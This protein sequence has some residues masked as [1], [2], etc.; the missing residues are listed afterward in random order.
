MSKSR[1]DPKAVLGLANIFANANQ[2]GTLS[3]ASKNLITGNLGAVVIAG[4]AGKDTEDILTSDVTLVTLLVDASS[5]IHQRGLE[6][7]V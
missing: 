6:D 3:N 1:I 5:S 4:A 7:A 2:G